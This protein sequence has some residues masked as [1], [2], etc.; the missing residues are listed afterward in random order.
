MPECSDSTDDLVSMN[1]NSRSDVG[2]DELP[3]VTEQ[4]ETQPN[5]LWLPNLGLTISDKEAILNNEALNSQI[6]EAVNI[7]A[8][9]RF[10]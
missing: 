5:S 6:I 1:N 4:I 10:H 3:D 7:L 2:V 9:N 8:R